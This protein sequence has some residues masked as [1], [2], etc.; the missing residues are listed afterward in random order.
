MGTDYDWRKAEAKFNALP[1][2]I[3]TIDGVDIQFIHIR[4]KH[5]GAMPLLMT[6]GWP[7][8]PPPTRRTRPAPI[9]KRRA[10]ISM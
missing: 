3:T 5:K 4:S 8:S 10:A 1:Q 7:G 6:Y 9:R 2:F